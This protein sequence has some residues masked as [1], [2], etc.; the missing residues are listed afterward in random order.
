MTMAV[1][2]APLSVGA[3]VT[4]GL[5]ASSFSLNNGTTFTKNE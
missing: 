2:A 4:S 3:V 5:M 1:A